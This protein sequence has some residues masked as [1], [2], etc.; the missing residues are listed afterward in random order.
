[1]LIAAIIGYIGGLKIKK[2]SFL[3]FLTLPFLI[4]KVIFV[5]EDAYFRD[6]SGGA[7]LREVVY[8]TVGLP[9]SFIS[10]LFCHIA[11]EKKLLKGKSDK[12]NA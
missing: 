4:I 12:N 1:M 11:K 10:I 7:S 8:F 2:Y 5:I 6:L 3:I 9:A